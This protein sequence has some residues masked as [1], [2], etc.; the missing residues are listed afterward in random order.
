MPALVTLRERRIA[1]EIGAGQVV[2]QDLVGGVEEVAP[3]I[4]EVGKQR[5]LVIKQAVMATVEGVLG[6][7]GEV[8]TQKIGQRRVVEPMAMQTPFAARVDEPVGDQDGEDRLPVGAL[9]G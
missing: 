6:G 2:E 4:V 9:A 1:L 7:Q 5:L 3:S 8:T